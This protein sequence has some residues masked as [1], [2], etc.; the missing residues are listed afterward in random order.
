MFNFEK[1]M[2][3]YKDNLFLNIDEVIKKGTIIENN[4]SE[5]TCNNHLLFQ[6]TPIDGVNINVNEKENS[7]SLENNNKISNVITDYIKTSNKYEIKKNI[8]CLNNIRLKNERQIGFDIHIRDAEDST[9]EKLI[10]D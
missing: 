9:F 7:E 1:Q 5:M 3:N 8:I 10:I 6:S 2:I 4:N